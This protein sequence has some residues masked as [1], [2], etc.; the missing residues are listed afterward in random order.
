MTEGILV[1]CDE[2]RTGGW[3]SLIASHGL[4]REESKAK[5]LIDHTDASWDGK[6]LNLQLY[7]YKQHC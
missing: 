5:R 1:L 2:D 3:V 6:C 7:T 4:L